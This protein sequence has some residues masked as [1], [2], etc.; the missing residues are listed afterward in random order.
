MDQFRR[1]TSVGYPAKTTP[2]GT[3]ITPCDERRRVDSRNIAIAATARARGEP[4]FLGD[5]CIG[6]HRPETPPL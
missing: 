5:Q 3:I 2:F 1:F 4:K 6:S